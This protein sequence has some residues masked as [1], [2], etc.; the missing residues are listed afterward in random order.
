MFQLKEVQEQLVETQ[1][2]L[3]RVTR[4]KVMLMTEVENVKGHLSSSVADY[5]QV[6][7]LSKPS[8]Y[9]KIISVIYFCNNSW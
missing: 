9:K 2:Q 8:Q 4:D 3:D 5:G 7:Q 1:L 6:S